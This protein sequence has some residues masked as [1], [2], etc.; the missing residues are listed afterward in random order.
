VIKYPEQN[1]TKPNQT[2]PN[3]TK[4]KIKSNIKEKGFIVAHK[5]RLQSII[6]GKSKLQEVETASHITST[7]KHKQKLTHMC[8]LV[9]V[10]YMLS[11]LT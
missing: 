9:P 5:A 11:V 8:F 2:K 1:Q 4:P 6:S 7:L 3:Q 10:K